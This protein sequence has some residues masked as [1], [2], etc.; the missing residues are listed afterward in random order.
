MSFA[1]EKEFQYVPLVEEGFWAVGMAGLELTKGKYE[2][3]REAGLG[4]VRRKGEM[5]NEA[6]VAEPDR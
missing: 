2:G 5:D 1:R 3:T 4:S 6:I